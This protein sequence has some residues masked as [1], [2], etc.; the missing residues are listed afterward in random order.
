MECNKENTHII[1]CASIF[2]VTLAEQHQDSSCSYWH[3]DEIVRQTF[4]SKHRYKPTLP[5]YVKSLKK[6]LSCRARED[7]FL[8]LGV[9]HPV[10]SFHYNQSA[11]LGKKGW[12]SLT[13]AQRSKSGYEPAEKTA[14]SW[15]G[16]RQ[17]MTVR[18]G[19]SPFTYGGRDCP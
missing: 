1:Y 9:K 7:I 19:G 6:D 16:Q 3:S 2:W 10:C 4:K 11:V 8:A 17:R 14:P 12:K 15:N 13:V 18:A 5:T